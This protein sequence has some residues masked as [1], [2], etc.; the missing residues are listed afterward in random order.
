MVISIIILTFALW[1][2]HKKLLINIVIAM[3]TIVTDGTRTVTFDIPM[4]E[5]EKRITAFAEM[6]TDEGRGL[7]KSVKTDEEERALANEIKTSLSKSE[8]LLKFV[9]G[10]LDDRND[11]FPELLPDTEINADTFIEAL[12]KNI[13]LL[14]RHNIVNY[15]DCVQTM[16]TLADVSVAA[17]SP[18]ILEIL[19]KGTIVSI[20]GHGSGIIKDIFGL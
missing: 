14:H 17:L 19:K 7:P 16:L 20:F 13:A 6:A 5:V 11:K 9:E 8:N 2:Y 3:N 10:L 4:E 1:K 12:G 18:F 15:R